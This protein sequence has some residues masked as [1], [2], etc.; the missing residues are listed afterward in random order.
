MFLRLC[1]RLI[2]G[3]LTNAVVLCT[4]KCRLARIPLHSLFELLCEKNN[5]EVRYMNEA[6]KDPSNLEEAFQDIIRFM[7]SHSCRVYSA[8]SAEKRR[9]LVSQDTRNLIVELQA[10]GLSYDRIVEELDKR[11]VRGFLKDGSPRR[12]SDNVVCKVLADHSR[13]VEASGCGVSPLKTEALDRFVALRVSS[14]AGETEA[15]QLYRDYCGFCKEKGLAP[16]TKMALS[17]YLI[18][19]GYKSRFTS[20]R[21]G[22]KRLKVRVWALRLNEQR[23]RPKGS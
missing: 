7:H 18:G 17:T 19:R 13:L 9:I 11:E 1:E 23:G 8:R 20:A 6:D 15:D 4:Y 5:V 3:D 16:T 14:V 2:Q 10:S 21:F 12:I 22:T